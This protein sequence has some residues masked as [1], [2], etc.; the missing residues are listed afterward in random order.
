MKR[1]FD[2]TIALVGLVVASPLLALVT[3]LILSYDRHSPFYFAKRAA[4][5][6]G[7]FRMVK[8]RS[9]VVNGEAIGGSS[10][11]ATDRR[12]TPIGRLVRAYKLDELAQ[13]WNVLMGDMSFVGPRPQVVFDTEMYTVD[14]SRLLSVRPGITDLASIVFSD[15]GHILAGSPDPDLRYQQVIR[16]WKNRLALLCI[17]HQSFWLDLC[18]IVLTVV[19]IVFRRT[20]LRAVVA[21]LRAWE[22]DP[23]VIRMAAREEPL[24]EYP[25]PGALEVV[26]QWSGGRPC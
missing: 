14:E 13:L 7:S 10:T 1:V 25:P 26:S 12:I 9:M 19:A 22:T 4:R 16:P 18:M 11:A 2:F 15:E 23:L 6:G 20:A 8:F 21:L 17:D 5:G 3:L 24:L